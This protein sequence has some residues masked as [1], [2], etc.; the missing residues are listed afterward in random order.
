MALPYDQYYKRAYAMLAPSLNAEYQKAQSGL[1][2]QGLISSTAGQGA[3]ADTR[4]KY[5]AAAQQQ[6]YNMA[7]ADRAFRE[8]H[9]LAWSANR[10]N[11]FNAGESRRQYNQN[12]AEGQRQYNSNLAKGYY[13]SQLG[14]AISRWQVADDPNSVKYYYKYAPTGDPL[15]QQVDEQGRPYLQGD[16]QMKSWPTTGKGMGNT[17]ANVTAERN[18]ELSLR[19]AALQDAQEKRLAAAQLY[20]QKLNN[21]Q[22]RIAQAESAAKLGTGAAADPWADTSSIIMAGLKENMSADNITSLLKMRGVD[23]PAMA[24]AG[25]TKAVEALRLLYGTQFPAA[26]L[27][28]VDLSKYGYERSVAPLTIDTNTTAA[29]TSPFGAT[30]DA[31]SVSP[32]HDN[33]QFVRDFL[34]GNPAN[35]GVKVNPIPGLGK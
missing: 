26:A 8:Q 19:T 17:Q 34:Y 1:A 20:A 6:A 2:D 25:D 15:E 29:S 33:T 9:N 21:A 31:V 28:S 35:Y 24:K 30:P 3:L 16:P 5:M 11:Q 12:F 23:L 13:D 27:P 4:G 14:S 7:Q 10:L 32:I 22:L 18:Y